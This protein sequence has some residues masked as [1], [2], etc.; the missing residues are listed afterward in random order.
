LNADGATCWPHP[1]KRSAA[2]VRCDSESRGSHLRRYP[3]RRDA[4][5]AQPPGRSAGPGAGRPAMSGQGTGPSF[6]KLMKALAP[7]DVVITPAVDRLS[8]G[9]TD[10]LVIARDCSEPE[11]A[12][13]RLPSR[14]S[15]RPR[16]LPSLSL[17][18][19]ALR[20]SSNAPHSRTRRRQG[21]ISITRG[22]VGRQH[23]QHRALDA[24][25]TRR[26]RRRGARSYPHPDSRGQEPRQGPRK[27]HG[28]TPLRRAQG[29]SLDELARSYNVSRA[30]ISRLEKR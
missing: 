11:R 22:A 30:T 27:A 16:T 5:A 21:A 1:T 15:I 19:W 2:A 6:Q 14:L 8:R 7:G 26:P 4:A 12:C 24:G 18:C 3:A 13:V 28:P 29:A 20:R 25:G 23:Q 9:A 17:P 10:L